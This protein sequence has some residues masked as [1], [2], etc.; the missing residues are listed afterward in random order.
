MNVEDVEGPGE[1]VPTQTAT[2][3]QPQQHPSPGKSINKQSMQEA[4]KIELKALN[5]TL[6]IERSRLEQLVRVLEVCYA[7]LTQMLFL[8]MSNINVDARS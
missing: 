4:E 3:N 8:L 5:R 1:D 7:F 2:R 6:D